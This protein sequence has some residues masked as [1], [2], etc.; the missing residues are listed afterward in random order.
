MITAIHV[1]WVCTPPAKGGQINTTLLQMNAYMAISQTGN[2]RSGVQSFL[3]DY[4]HVL[5]VLV[6]FVLVFL[7]IALQ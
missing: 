1:H 3:N 4:I 5:F 6:V 2:E 7:C